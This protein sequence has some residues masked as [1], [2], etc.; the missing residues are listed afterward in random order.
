MTISHRNRVN[1]Q[2]V[3]TIPDS[4][5]ENC[6]KTY[7]PK[8]SN[9]TRFCSRDCAFTAQR[10][11][12][13]NARHNPDK[14]Q[15]RRKNWPKSV[16]WCVACSICCTAFVSRKKRKRCAACA[17][18]SLKP[19]E[20]KS[21]PC[22]RGCGSHV[23]GDLRKKYCRSCVRKRAALATKQKHGKG[24]KNRHRAKRYGV[25][26]EPINPVAV[27]KRDRWRCQICGIATPERL[28]GT[29]YD[30]APELDHRIPMSK[31]GPHTWA[32]VQ[33]S[34]RKCNHRKGATIIAGQMS[35]FPIAA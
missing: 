19:V 27:F 32:N 12:K 6:S 2:I 14:E 17:V 34:C 16:I 9:R 10:A 7:R 20:P 31:G 18:A 8:R 5:C 11:G 30:R 26:Y 29:H 1:G 13:N 3:R 4:V 15:A 28:R 33:C 21:K 35:L 22:A 25:T 23:F 24:K